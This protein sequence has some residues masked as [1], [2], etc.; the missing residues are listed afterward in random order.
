MAFFAIFTDTIR[1]AWRLKLPVVLCVSIL[2]LI[3]ALPII[4]KSDGTYAGSM[5]LFFLYSGQVQV[6]FLC[7]LATGWSIWMEKYERSQKVHI[8]IASRP[9]GRGKVLFARAFASLFICLFFLGALNTAIGLIAFDIEKKSKEKDSTSALSQF[10]EVRSKDALVPINDIDHKK[11]IVVKGFIKNATTLE[12]GESI[13]FDLNLNKLNTD[14][15]LS[16][17]LATQAVKTN[18]VLSVILSK[19]NNDFWERRIEIQP[20]KEFVLNLPNAIQKLSPLKL[21]IKQFNKKKKAFY[22]LQSKPIYVTNYYGTIWPNLFRGAATL[23]IKGI[24]LI[25]ISI[26]AAQFL[27]TP[28]SAF[29]TISIYIIGFFKEDIRTMLFPPL[30]SFQE[31][32]ILTSLNPVE[33]FYIIVWKPILFFIPDFSLLNPTARIVNGELISWAELGFNFMSVIPFIAIISIY[34]F[35]FIPNQELARDL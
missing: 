12:H 33:L 24:L 1:H 2:I 23:L 19:D 8:M 30:R 16:G 13:Q 18:A 26:A 35:Y 22:Y 5:K 7:I 28:G 3:S 6:F 31:E 15:Q 29:T 21:K 32:Q 14:Y 25:F 4:L 17:S 10:L 9:V 34:L 27:S 11:E 20:N